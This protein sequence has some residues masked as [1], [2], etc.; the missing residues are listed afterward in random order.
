MKINAKTIFVAVVV[1]L[2]IGLWLMNSFGSLKVDQVDDG[3]MVVL[4]NGCK[5]RLI[6]VSNTEQGKR[7]LKSLIGVEVTLQP[8]M[9][10]NFDPH[11]L[12]KG[13]IVDAYLL[14]NDNNY[15]CINATLL[16]KGM[17]E[18]VEG[19]HLVDSL[20]KFREYAQLGKQQRSV[21]PTP[22][23]QKINY[24]ADSIK[25]PQYTPQSE[26]RHNTWYEESEDNI[27]M[28]DEACDYNLPYTKVFANQLAARSPGEFS[29]E[30][31]CEI[32]D[33]CY[34]KWRYVND[35]NGQDYIAR[36][37]ESI[38]A[39]LTGDCDDFAVLIASCV[40]ACGGNACIVY[41]NGS[42][43]CH[44]YSEVDIQSLKRNKDISYI[45]DVIRKKY[46]MY[47]MSTLGMRQDNG[48]TW[49]NLDWQAA[50]PGG[51]YF[52]AESKVFYS[53]IDGKWNFSQ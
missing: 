50:Y 2:L 13:D 26:R 32:F 16:K 51:P 36:A 40:L 7:E 23:I 46:P 21:N 38:S 12:T 45:E 44:A 10:A 52:Q 35:P 31:V 14:L 19:G 4:N 8:D 49:L 39:S 27:E 29:I 48:H 1:I 22:I 47:S 3:D 42:H 9:S 33:Y 15:E 18:L 17:A 53:V 34:N 24:A 43:G 30:Q 25:L 11:L 5:I 37:S 41:A 20:D 6:G 28:L